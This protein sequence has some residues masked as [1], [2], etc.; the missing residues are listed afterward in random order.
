MRLFVES[1]YRMSKGTDDEFE[2][3]KERGFTKPSIFFLFKLII[4]SIQHQ[5]QRAIDLQHCYL[6]PHK[7]AYNTT[8]PFLYTCHLHHGYL[9]C[10]C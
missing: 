3:F 9:N 10:Q 7:L 5:H 6:I 2:G 4:I 1:E 8:L